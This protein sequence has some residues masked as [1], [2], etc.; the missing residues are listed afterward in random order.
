MNIGPIGSTLETDHPSGTSLGKVNGSWS[1]NPSV[2]TYGQADGSSVLMCYPRWF[3]SQGGLSRLA[4]VDG[5]SV[6]LPVF[7]H[8]RTIRRATVLCPSKGWDGLETD[9]PSP[10]KIDPLELFIN[11]LE[12]GGIRKQWVWILVCTKNILKTSFSITMASQ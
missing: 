7:I 11:A 9:D 10:I 4:R 12:T 3:V 6:C 1:D 2:Y 5:W 8:R